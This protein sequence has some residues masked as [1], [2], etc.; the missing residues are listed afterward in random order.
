MASESTAVVPA[1]HRV[2][3]NDDDLTC[4]RKLTEENSQINL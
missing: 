1:G 3:Y 4:A 2:Y